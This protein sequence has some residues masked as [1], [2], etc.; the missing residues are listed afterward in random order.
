[1][2]RANYTT[3][4]YRY[5]VRRSRTGGSDRTR[6]VITTSI[7]VLFIAGLITAGI[8]IAKRI[9]KDKARVLPAVEVERSELERVMPLTPIGS[10]RFL[11]REDLADV[12]LLG[13]FG[14]CGPGELSGQRAYADRYFG[15]P[16][17][18]AIE[19]KTPEERVGVGIAAWS[20]R[21]A[22]GAELGWRAIR[23]SI[24]TCGGIEPKGAAAIPG[25]DHSTFLDVDSAAAQANGSKL[26]YVVARW[27]RWVVATVASGE[28]EAIGAATRLIEILRLL[29]ASLTE[30]TTTTEA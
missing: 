8:V 21:T 3:E 26:R 12:R 17:S 1:M 5:T 6:R 25:S 2:P 11:A 19:A 10:S 23:S 16:G 15:V 20:F 29:D 7:F 13:R 27:D 14:T 22:D 9:D 4:G 18:L 24:T 28:G 30:A